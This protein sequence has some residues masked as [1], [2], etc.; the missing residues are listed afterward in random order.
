ME[1]AVEVRDPSGAW[2]GGGLQD[3]PDGEGVAQIQANLS[4]PTEVGQGC[5]WKS[6]IRPRGTTWRESVYAL[7]FVPFQVVKEPR[8]EISL[9]SPTWPYMDTE[10]MVE[11][12]VLYNALEKA[13]LHLQLLRTDHPAIADSTIKVDAGSDSLEVELILNTK[14]EA[15]KDYMIIGQLV[16]EADGKLLVADTL[17]DL[18]FIHVEDP[19]GII[20]GEKEIVEFK[21][22]PNPASESVFV[23]LFK[24]SVSIESLTLT[25][26]TGR[27]L[28]KLGKDALSN[29]G[30]RMEL[31]ISS[32][33]SGYYFLSIFT[34]NGEYTTGLKID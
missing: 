13:Q 22:Y 17:K 1:I 28:L 31:D 12:S 5:S 34:N 33:S 11:V 26:I 18:E 7:D 6:H 19:V 2:I 20:P 15:A 8:N 24:P 3:V 9:I 10:G 32:L 16:A 23:E 4:T 21:V 29:Q 25:D 30:K 27:I 14:P